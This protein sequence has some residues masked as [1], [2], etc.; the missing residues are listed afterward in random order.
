VCV[1][2]FCPEGS[3]KTLV[4]VCTE[5]CC[6]FRNKKKNVEISVRD[7]DGIRAKILDKFTSVRDN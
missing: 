2:R 3:T 7:A 4:G 6:C 1:C 5:K